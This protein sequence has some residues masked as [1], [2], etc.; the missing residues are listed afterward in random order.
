MDIDP[1][2]PK[3]ELPDDV[4]SFGTLN[5]ICKRYS[6]TV[7]HSEAEKIRS[8]GGVNIYGGG[9]RVT[10]DVAARVAE[11]RRLLDSEQADAAR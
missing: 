9:L 4:L 10:P 2:K 7:L 3:T 1:P 5:R 6:L 11:L 8:V